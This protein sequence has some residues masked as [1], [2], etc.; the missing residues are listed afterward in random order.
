MCIF[1]TIN[2]K[3][4]SLTWILLFPQIEPICYFKKKNQENYVYTKNHLIVHILKGKILW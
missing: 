3:K 1:S 2:K 4:T